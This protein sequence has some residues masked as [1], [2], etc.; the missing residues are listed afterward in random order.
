MNWA[1]YLSYVAFTGL[2]VLVPGADFTV[3]VKNS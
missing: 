3:I 1:S 2:L